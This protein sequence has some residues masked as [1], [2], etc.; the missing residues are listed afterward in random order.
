M[1]FAESPSSRAGQRARR[2]RAFPPSRPSGLVMG[3][4]A[5]ISAAARPPAAVPGTA[6]G[7]PPAPCSPCSR[8]CGRKP[9]RR[10]GSADTHS[11]ANSQAAAPRP[12]SATAS[13]GEPG[14]A[15]ARRVAR[16]GPRHGCQLAPPGRG[17]AQLVETGQQDCRAGRA[18]V[19]G[20]LLCHQLTGQ[21]E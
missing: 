19:A 18:Q 20:H 17:H 8:P 14:E 12:K 7:P 15:V 4:A 2:G 3:L 13:I 21:R 10:P 1:K 5:R 11:R 6:Q 16:P 9:V